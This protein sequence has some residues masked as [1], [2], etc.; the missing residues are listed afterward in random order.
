MKHGEQ[1]SCFDT[2]A[3]RRLHDSQAVAVRRSRLRLRRVW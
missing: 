1:T 2:F 3:L